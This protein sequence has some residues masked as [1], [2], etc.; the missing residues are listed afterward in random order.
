[1]FTF[2][3]YLTL[4]RELRAWGYIALRITWLLITSQDEWE[5]NRPWQQHLPES[6][7]EYC[8]CCFQNILPRSSERNYVLLW[9]KAC[10]LPVSLFLDLLLC[11]FA[12]AKLCKLFKKELYN[13]IPNI[14]VWRLLRRRLYLKAYKL[15]IV[16]GVECWTVDSLYAF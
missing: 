2:Y 12:R 10:V 4:L 15:S 5:R 7:E 6:N 14:T 8:W 3:S 13:G 9:F 16:Q 11:S 1:V